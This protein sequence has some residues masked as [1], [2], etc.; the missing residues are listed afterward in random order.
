MSYL[1]SLKLTIIECYTS[2]VYGLKDGGDTS[3]FDPYVNDVFQYMALACAAGLSDSIDSVK[4]ILGLVG[5]LADLYGKKVQN[6]LT[7]P[8]IPHLLG[9]A[10]KTVGKEY[11]QFSRWVKNAIAKA[12]K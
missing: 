10:D 5:D 7:L 9:L 1:R 2:I 11:K 8:F 12:M 4:T 6:L 3:I